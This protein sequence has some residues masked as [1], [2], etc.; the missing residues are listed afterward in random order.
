[1]YHYSVFKEGGKWAAQVLEMPDETVKRYKTFTD[2]KMARTQLSIWK[3][4][5]GAK[6]EGHVGD[7]GPAPI[8]AERQRI[9]AKERGAMDRANQQPKKSYA[10]IDFSGLFKKKKLQ[11]HVRPDGRPWGWT[12]ESVSSFITSLLE[13]V[14]PRRQESPGIDSFTNAYMTCALW[15]STGDDGEH[16]D[17]TYCVG[18]I[19]SECFDKME[20][21]CLKFQEQNHQY[22]EDLVV[23]SQSTPDEKAGHYFWLTRNGHGAGFWDGDYEEEAG[24]A[25]TAAAEA[26]GECDLYVG[27]DGEL[28]CTP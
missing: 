23:V 22:F 5:F 10:D 12:G 20:A 24:R 4:Q 14:S 26:F 18:D 27:D 2:E 16:L 1:M 7:L 11:G 9:R 15:S 25:L 3:Q 19:S 28:Y 13:E 6:Q 21:D 8:P 17:K